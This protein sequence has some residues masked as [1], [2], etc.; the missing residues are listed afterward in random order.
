MQY[1]KRAKHPDS[2]E[3]HPTYI[4]REGFKIFLPTEG[5]SKATLSAMQEY[6]ADEGNSVK[7]HMGIKGDSFSIGN[8]RFKFDWDG[9]SKTI[10][11]QKV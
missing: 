1:H 5:L 7:D 11:L 9:S 10:H 8:D 6:F 3:W 2:G 4:S